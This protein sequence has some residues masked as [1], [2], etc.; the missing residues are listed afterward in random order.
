MPDS[1][2]HSGGKIILSSHLVGKRLEVLPAES[3]E[4]PAQQESKKG[5]T[6]KR[7]YILKSA[8]A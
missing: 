6:M 8:S 2:T 4:W 7:M 5:D 3:N 1:A